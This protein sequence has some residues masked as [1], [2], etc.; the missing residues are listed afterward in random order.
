V[1]PIEQQEIKGFSLKNLYA[2]IV[3]TTLIVSSVIGTYFKVS[4][5][6]E[7]IAND[8]AANIKYNDLRMK[9]L[10]QKLDI[11][12]ISLKDLQSKYSIFRDN[13]IK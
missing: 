10:E 11:M 9:V 13:N 1:T 2:V 7:R 5:Q 6:I 3:A 12:E 8:N 4:T